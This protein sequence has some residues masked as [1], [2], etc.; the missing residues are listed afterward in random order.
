MCFA[1]KF[2][3]EQELL[4]LQSEGLKQT[5]K[6]VYE[7]NPFYRNLLDLADVHPDS[8]R[9]LEDLTRL[10][11]TSAQDLRNGHPFPLLCAPFEDIVRIHSTSGTTGQRK[12][13]AYTERDIREWAVMMARCLE[14]AGCTTQDRLQIAV[15]YGV[16]TAGAGFQ[17]GCETLGAMA[18][19]VGPGN[20]DL[21]C[22]F[23]VELGSTAICCTSSMALL[24][25]E[26][27]IRRDLLDK[28]SLKRVIYGSERTSDARRKWISESLGVEL[29]DITGMT[30]LFGP[31]VGIE[32]SAHL[33]IH[34]FAD[35]YILEILDP[36]T[37][38]PTEPG[39]IGEMVVTTL[40]KE[41]SPLIRYRTRDLTRLLPGTCPCGSPLPRHDRL[42]GRSDDTFKFRAVN[43]NPTQIDNIL[44][45]IT[46]LGSEFRIIIEH[47]EDK[48]DYM[49]VVVERASHA[50]AESDDWCREKVKKAIKDQ[51][52]VSANVD[53]VDYGSLSRCE[54][55]TV[56][57]LDKRFS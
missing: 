56:R 33:G 31:G 44:S 6:R 16:W 21:Q 1:P 45:G 53:I 7:N 51:I 17:Q 15:G 38:Q 30:E 34:Y 22:R 2:K 41:A 48:R 8:F 11:F 29:F 13:M 50:L 24:L 40:S 27:I 52:L 18:I 20:L 23:L 3:N 57:V 55:K 42:F 39:E 26:E 4:D 5:I 28:I 32:C 47:G 19:P 46:E 36:V 49:N 9:G 12:I 14:M 54:G 37:L 10:P 25:S 35:H 43:V